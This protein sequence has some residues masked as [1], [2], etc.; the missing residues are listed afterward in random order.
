MRN[1]LTRPG[2]YDG[3]RGV[4]ARLHGDPLPLQP[5]GG[6]AA[7]RYGD[8]PELRG[9]GPVAL[10]AAAGVAARPG[11]QRAAH[12]G[13]PDRPG[14]EAFH[15]HRDTGRHPVGAARQP[16]AGDPVPADPVLH[17]LALHPGAHHGAAGVLPRVRGRRPVHAA[18]PLHVHQQHAV[19]DRAGR[20]RMGAPLPEHG[21]LRP[22]LPPHG[23]RHPG[24]ARRGGGSGPDA[25]AD[26]HD[27]PLQLDSHGELLGQGR[28]D[29]PAYFPP[30][31]LRRAVGS[32]PRLPRDAGLCGLAGRGAGLRPHPDPRVG[33][34]RHVGAVPLPGLRPPGRQ[35]VLPGHERR[36]RALRPAP[37]QPRA[38]HGE[39]R[40]DRAARQ[41]HGHRHHHVDHGDPSLRALSAA[42]GGWRDR[43]LAAAA[44]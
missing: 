22:P 5:A 39:G 27:D 24:P 7:P 4:R 31:G 38:G 40:G 29:R 28:G 44:A 37:H 10:P 18:R 23:G 32:L 15:A 11:P 14:E 21:G 25:L 1:E 3:A 8:L 30:G 35:A 2:G 41:R 42:P 36:H 26:Q 19:R 17:R 33:P 43:G 6:V 12:P 13:I 9:R 20:L 34:D 16:A